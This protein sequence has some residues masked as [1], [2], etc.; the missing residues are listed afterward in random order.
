LLRNSYHV[1]TLDTDAE[2]IFTGSLSF[3]RSHTPAA[4]GS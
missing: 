2:E 3:V 4:F 1:A